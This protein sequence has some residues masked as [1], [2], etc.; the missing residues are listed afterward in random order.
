[1]KNKMH[2]PHVT[3]ELNTGARVPTAIYSFPRVLTQRDF[4]SGLFSLSK[5]THGSVHGRYTTSQ[6]HWTHR[7]HWFYCYDCLYIPA[8]Y[9]NEQYPGSFSWQRQ[10]SSLM[11]ASLHLITWIVYEMPQPI[12][13]TYGRLTHAFLETGFSSSCGCEPSIHI[14]AYVPQRQKSGFVVGISLP[15]ELSKRYQVQ[16]LMKP[17]SHSR[18]FPLVVSTLQAVLRRMSSIVVKLD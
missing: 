1:M 10:N 5:A 16:S 15:A 18:G 6:I 14:G 2:S 4:R 3:T 8:Q 9:A 17:L 11:L 7:Q 12:G 13:G